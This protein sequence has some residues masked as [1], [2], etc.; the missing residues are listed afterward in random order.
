[1]LDETLQMTSSPIAEQ[2]GCFLLTLEGDLDSSNAQEVTKFVQ[3]LSEKE[4]LMHLVADFSNLR[5]INSTG[6]GTIL[7]IS[8]MLVG[9]KGTFKIANPNDNVY[10]I[11]EIVGANKLLEVYPTKE[12][13]LSALEAC[14]I[15]ED[16]LSPED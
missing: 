7:R 14:P 16:D 11:I 3:N 9:K 2:P 5:Y 6:L 12:A 13:A 15:R 8:K 1:M 4:G 10:E